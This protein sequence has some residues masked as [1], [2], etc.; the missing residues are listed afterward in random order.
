[1]LA[2]IASLDPIAFWED[3][4]VGDKAKQNYSCA[5]LVEGKK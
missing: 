3:S 1:M 4:E 5:P 2:V